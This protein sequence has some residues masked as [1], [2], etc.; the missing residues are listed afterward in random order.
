[1]FEEESTTPDH[2]LVVR[3]TVYLYIDEARAVA[4]RLVHER[5]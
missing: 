4:E 1:M 5:G 3:M 2:D